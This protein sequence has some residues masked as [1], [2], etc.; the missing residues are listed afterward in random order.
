MAKKKTKKKTVKTTKRK[1]IK[2]PPKIYMDSRGRYIRL[3]GKKVR[4]SDG[5]SNKQIVNIVLND[6]SINRK[7]KKRRKKIDK[8]IK[9]KFDE[10]KPSS[11]GDTKERK[12]IISDLS[13][14][15]IRITTPKLIKAE[16]ERNLLGPP[17]PDI[18][19]IDRKH[20][21]IPTLTTGQ[22]VPA[23]GNEGWN[24]ELGD[25][26][27]NLRTLQPLSGPRGEKLFTIAF[28][29]T[30]RDAIAGTIENE[31]KARKLAEQKAEETRKLAEQKET[32]SKR[33]I[34]QKEKEIK[35]K[36]AILQKK[37]DEEKKR[38]KV[39]VYEY[40][41]TGTLNTL[42]SRYNALLTK[43]DEND[44]NII[45]R[46][47]KG[48][49]A[50]K[51]GKLLNQIFD[52]GILDKSWFENDLINEI[53]LND[54]KESKKRIRA[55]LLSMG[56]IFFAEVEK[57]KVLELVENIEKEEV[58]DPEELK[59]IEEELKQQ[60]EPIEEA[61]IL[62]VI[63]EEPLE[64]K[65]NPPESEEEDPETTG[66]G[67]SNRRGTTTSQINNI[68]KH[69]PEYVG[70]YAMDQMDLIPAKDE[71][72]FIINLDDST[73]RGSHWV[74]CYI[75]NNDCIEYYDSYGRDPPKTFMDDIQY[76]ISKLKPSSYMKFKINRIVDQS[77]TSDNC[78]YF[79][80][81]FL[82]DR[83]AGVPFKECTGYNM[84]KGE[85][86]INVVKNK[87]KKF[88]YI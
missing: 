34:E 73:Q 47:E 20:P 71:M 61:T 55:K 21:A 82:A 53:D 23:I 66:S 5:I 60:I 39:L 67:D 68:M 80:M 87:L 72:G 27:G 31:L 41:D 85:L 9:G 65:D 33:V 51:K 36:D 40:T 28:T 37:E 62:P 11:F 19:K 58:E 81:K 59:Q 44:P 32:K 57:E 6:L 26:I 88:R 52:K 86:G 16:V 13:Q 69:F 30:Q 2:R 17:K 1:V 22:P 74:A 24:Q 14:P 54:A 43:F 50:Q 76:I 8:K 38:K 46:R 45:K 78:G 79:A 12:Y 3:G 18:P 7:R 15:D 83:F 4:I 63:E 64:S 10:L 42:I 29:E 25:V 56:D 77:A 35:K 84:V 48:K 75:L 70:T 49:S